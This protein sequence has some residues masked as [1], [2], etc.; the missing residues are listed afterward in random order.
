MTATIGLYLCASPCWWVGQQS[1]Q[2]F[3]SNPLLGLRL[4]SCVWLFLPFLSRS[5]FGVVLVIVMVTCRIRCIRNHFGWTTAKWGG[6][7]GQNPQENEVCR[8][9]GVGKLGGE[10]HA[11]SHRC[12]AIQ[13]GWGEKQC[14]PAL[15][16][17]KSLL[18]ITALPVHTLSLVNKSHI[19]QALFKLLIPCCILEGL[20]IILSL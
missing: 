14:P 6:L 7:Y 5:H 15:L 17:G 1:D 11:S 12:L 4:N 19:F 9:H 13:A 16:F 8:V 18:K 2:M 20:F 3:A 10:C